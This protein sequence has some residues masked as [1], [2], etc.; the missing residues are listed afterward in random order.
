MISFDAIGRLAIGQLP[1]SNVITLQASSGSYALT[2]KPLTF[3]VSFVANEGS[4]TEA[5]F[6]TTFVNGSAALGTGHFAL[7]GIPISVSFGFALDQGSYVLT[8]ESITYTRD[9]EA[10]FPRPF[11]KEI[12]TV[13][14]QSV[15]PV[16][17][18]T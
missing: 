2:G 18:S 3:Q 6:P 11:P 12:W 14:A 17:P 5:G 10:W 7:S 4:F 13:K 1:A 9:F 16:I 8:G 15:L